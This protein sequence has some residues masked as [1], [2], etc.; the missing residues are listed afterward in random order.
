[1]SR[2]RRLAIGISVVVVSACATIASGK[3]QAI[4]VSSNVEGADVFLDGIL[5]GQT[6]FTGPVAKNKRFS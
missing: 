6:P 2:L 3:T 1:M 4:S 5:I